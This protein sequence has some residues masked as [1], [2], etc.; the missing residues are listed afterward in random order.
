METK[1]ELYIPNG[2]LLSL[3]KKEILPFPAPRI[4]LKD[5]ML[6]EMSQMQKDK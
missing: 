2:K 6:R 5:S 4:S 1:N 3:T